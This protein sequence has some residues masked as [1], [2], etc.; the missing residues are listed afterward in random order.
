M[1]GS[2]YSAVEA[3][4]VV[5]QLVD[6][7]VDWLAY[8][9]SLVDV[10][11]PRLGSEVYV[12]HAWSTGALDRFLAASPNEHR[13][14]RTDDVDPGSAAAREFFRSLLSEF[15]RAGAGCR[16]GPTERS[17]EVIA[18]GLP[19][20]PHGRQARAPSSEVRKIDGSRTSAVPFVSGRLVW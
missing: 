10:P 18:G 6:R 7:Y 15:G 5:R 9:A 16:P 13:V 1:S 3:D 8:L 19:A 20:S 4:V 14:T 2:T 11:L 12:L 17:P